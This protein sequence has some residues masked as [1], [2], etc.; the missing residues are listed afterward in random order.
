MRNV[1]ILLLVAAAGVLGVEGNGDP[2]PTDPT[3]P[4]PALRARA[5]WVCSETL[6]NPEEIERLVATAAA[7][8]IDTLF[9][10]VRRAGDAYYTSATEPRS[11]KL[12]G[13]APDFDPL[14]AVIADAR[15]FGIQVHAW[16]NV[17]YCWPGPE[18]PPMKSHVAARHPEWITVGRDG[19]R[20]TSYSKKEM[21]R[22]DT[23]GWY[24]EPSEPSFAAYFAAV[25]GEVAAN[26]E[27]AGVHLDFIR[28]PN[29]RFG[30]G[31]R[32]R[33]AY[34][35]AKPGEPD[36]R[37]LGYHK[38]DRDIF[39]PATGAAGLADRWFDLHTLEWY[40]WRARQIERI[41]ATAGGAVHEAKPECV[42]S[43]AVWAN[44]EH[45]YR[46]VGQ[47]WL[48]WSERGLVDI[49]VP[50]T[51]WGNADKLGAVAERLARRRADTCRVYLGVGTF[52]HDPA[53]TAA[54]VAGLGDCPADG[55]VLFDY[56]SCWRKP[57]TLP[58]LAEV[59]PRVEVEPCP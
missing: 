20:L 37:L 29:I 59:C 3:P 16:L 36:P 41:V 47:D 54:T 57:E 7:Y 39:R 2:V 13:Q 10:Q 31:E 19:R 45:A 33:A 25:A 6:Q 50:M 23:E 1:F 58:R 48:G 38:S 21:A 55:F 44:P 22:A 17:V 52:N 35:K 15:P 14:A 43:A 27:V 46:Y 5:M 30:Y 34:R 9:V 4:A 32:A 11:R 26:Y 42:Y 12:A 51:Y 40:D 24:V 53:Y 8:G 56:D 28:Y 49:L 18:L